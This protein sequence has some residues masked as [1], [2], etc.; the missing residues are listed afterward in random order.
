MTV[1]LMNCPKCGKRAS[2]YAP[3]KWE[4]LSCGSRFVYEPPLKPDKYIR[5]EAAVVRQLASLDKSAHGAD[6]RNRD[7]RRRPGKRS[8]VG[9]VRL[10]CLPRLLDRPEQRQV[11]HGFPPRPQQRQAETLRTPSA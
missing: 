1:N 3:N 6:N 7:A 4:C 8:G 5:Q 9:V 2:E 11:R 10:T